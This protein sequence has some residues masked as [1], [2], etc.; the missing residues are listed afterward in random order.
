MKKV[1]T[2]LTLVAV[3]AIPAVIAYPIAHTPT[4]GEGALSP[5]D[6]LMARI[7][8]AAQAAGGT[9]SEPVGMLPA[10]LT[11][12]LI[13]LFVLRL[14]LRR[15]PAVKPQRPARAHRASTALELIRDGARS[16]EV[17]VTARVSRDAVE[18]LR[19]TTVGHVGAGS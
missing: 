14:A 7:A 6:L 3:L 2:V 4:G 5:R 9:V 18:L 16:D 13:G 17:M 8:E 10:L 15:P 19:H 1:K 11:V 12:A